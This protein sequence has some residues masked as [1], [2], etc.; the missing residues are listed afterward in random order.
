MATRSKKQPG[1]D[2]EYLRIRNDHT[3]ENG[4]RYHGHKSEFPF[5]DDRRTT[6]GIVWPDLTGRKPFVAPLNLPL[7]KNTKILDIAARGGAWL[8]S[9]QDSDDGIYSKAR[10]TGLEPA[11]MVGDAGPAWLL[12]RDL[13]GPWPFTAK[14]A[15]HLIHS[16]AL[17]GLLKDWDG[18]YTNVFKHLV[19]GGWVEIREHNLKFCPREGKEKEMEGK[20]DAIQQWS[21]LM[22]EAAEKFGKKINMGAKQKELMEQTGLVDIQE[23]IFKIPTRVWKDD[24]TTK[25]GRYYHK[26]WIRNI[27][28]YSLR[29]F[30]K[31]LG[32]SKEDTDNLLKRVLQELDQEDLQLYS[33][34]YLIIGKKPTSATR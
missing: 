8:Y 21:E 28:G 5:P 29:L 18:F 16:E 13:E 2:L 27:E 19:P 15:F 31:T 4:R 32:W 33:L 14:E 10:L 24:P 9:L 1:H 22:D 17:G 20:W 25:N 23:Q 11:W 6:A 3:W 26:H 30:T 12:H 7:K 34:F